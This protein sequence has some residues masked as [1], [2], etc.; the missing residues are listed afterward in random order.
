[1]RAS[2]LSL[3]KSRRFLPLFLTQFLGAMNDNLFK[4]A[5]VI[6]ITYKLAAESGQDGALLVTVAAG[7]F[8]LPFFLFSALA[9]QIADRFEKSRLI[10]WVKLAEIAIMGT[11]VAALY[12]G[13]ILPL[14]IVLFLMGAQ[15]SLFGPLKYSILPDHLAERDL[16]AAN[17]LVEGGTFM[18]ILAGTIAGGLM[19]TLDRGIGIVA[20]AILGLAVLGWFSALAIP[21]SRVASPKLK[22]NPNILGET[23]SIIKASAANR[24]V[25]LSILGISWF[26]LIGATFLAQFPNLTNDILEADAKVVTLFLTLFSAGI[27]LGSILCNRLLKGALS[28]RHVPLGALGMTVFILDFYFALTGY[29]PSSDFL[30][31]GADWRIMADLLGIAICGGLFI[32]PLYALMQARAAAEMRSRMVAANNIMNALFIVAGTLAAALMLALEVPLPVL[33][34][35][36]ALLNAAVAVYICGLLPETVLKSCLKWVLRVLFRVRVRGLEHCDRLGD[37]AVY[38]VNHV[39]FLDAVLLAAFLPGR[40]TFAINS[41]MARRWWVRPF[42]TFVDAY[43]MDPTNPMAIKGLIQAVREGRHCVIFPEGR[44]TVTGSLMK[45]HEGPGMIADK[46]DAPLVPVRIDG[47]QYSVFS[48][49]KGVVRRRLFPKVA[50]TILAPRRFQLEE[51]LSGHARREAAGAKLYD[52]MAELMFETQEREP[53]PVRGHAGCQGGSRRQRPG[54]GGY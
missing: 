47:A 45:V 27:A 15:S 41:H 16:I 13:A 29:V 1:M 24:P 30:S 2:E 48:R 6:L 19:I 31:Q 52:V 9:G 42:L 21:K 50:L 20:A 32:V 44:I 17:A 26:W 18:A 3:M 36:L 40:P 53:D 22:I 38:V 43:P 54:S 25:H 5:L 4:T 8:I 28:A 37:R 46:A 7:L 14:M 23:V 51:G 39:S 49:L 33:F 12:S 11:G 35:G 10:R 34:L